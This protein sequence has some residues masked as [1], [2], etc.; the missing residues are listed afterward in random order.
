M[1]YE[2]GDKLKNNATRI[3]YEIIGINAE[4]YHSL[5]SSCGKSRKRLQRNLD[6]FY[7]KQHV[8]SEAVNICLPDGYEIDS[9]K[10]DNKPTEAAKD[11]DGKLP[12]QLLCPIA[13]AGTARVLQFGRDKYTKITGKD[14]SH[15]WKM[16]MPWTK[17]IGSIMR[18][19]FA[20]KRGEDIDPDSGLPHVDHLGCEVMFLQSY[21]AQGVGKD[22][23]YK[24]NRGNQNDI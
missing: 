12:L 23:R 19:L 3:V 18:H 5:E 1:K 9:S 22:D 21:M 15:N 13:L 24:T 4:G 14:A 10:L 7:I 6:R 20:I 16:G 17:V 2:V 8:S 11:D